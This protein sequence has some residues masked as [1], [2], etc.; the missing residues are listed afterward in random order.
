[1]PNSRCSRT[2]SL[3]A[4]I[5]REAWLAA[6]GAVARTTRKVLRQLLAVAGILEEIILVEIVRKLRQRDS[7]ET[8]SHS[9]AK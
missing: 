9:A 8:G 1:V 2:T 5:E 3:S 6:N 4:R 7:E